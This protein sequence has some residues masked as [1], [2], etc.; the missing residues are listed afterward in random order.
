LIN[1]TY[2]EFATQADVEKAMQI[3]NNLSEQ[4]GETE[5]ERGTREEP[6]MRSL[7]MERFFLFC[8]VFC[9]VLFCFVLF[10]FVLF[11]F[12]LFC[13]VLFFVNLI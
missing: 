13:F 4:Q 10:C 5:P 11:C 3:T 2:V 9:F 8:F 1:R 6:D 7:L 12:V